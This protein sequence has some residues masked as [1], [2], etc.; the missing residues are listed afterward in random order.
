MLNC[1][2]RPPESLFC[3]Y[4]YSLRRFPALVKVSRSEANL[5]VPVDGERIEAERLEVVEVLELT[6]D[7]LL[8]QRCE[9]HQPHLTRAKRQAQCVVAHVLGSDDFEQWIV[10]CHILFLLYLFQRCNLLGSLAVRQAFPVLQQFIAM[11]IEPFKDKTQSPTR[12]FA[13][14][15]SFLDGDFGLVVVVPHMEMGRILA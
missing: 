5:V 9:V 12:H 7:A 6:A 10:C 8:H 4:I 2:H 15:N 14:Y 13:T 3:L 11:Q 1:Q